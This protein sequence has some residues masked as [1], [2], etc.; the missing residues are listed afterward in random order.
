MRVSARKGQAGRRDH[1]VD[2]ETEGAEKARTKRVRLVE[3]KH[4][5]PRIISSPLVVEFVGLPDRSAI[6][7]VGAGDCVLFRQFMI[8]FGREVIL[9][10]DLL[11]RKDENPGIPPDQQWAVRQRIK[12]IHKT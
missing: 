1:P 7:H 9:G 12:S 5:T 4:L 3:G 8:D 10:S 2:S 11:T 6:E